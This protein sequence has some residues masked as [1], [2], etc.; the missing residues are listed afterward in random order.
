M[1]ARCLPGESICVGISQ[2]EFVL[3]HLLCK[4]MLLCAILDQEEK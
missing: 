2:G 4:I 1:V 3:L